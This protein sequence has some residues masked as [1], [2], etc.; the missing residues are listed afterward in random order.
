M[1]QH[2]KLNRSTAIMKNIIFILLFLSACDALDE[3]QPWSSLESFS[4]Q[5]V[6]DIPS[7]CIGKI[8]TNEDAYQPPATTSTFF[9]FL[10]LLFIYLRT[11]KYKI[12]VLYI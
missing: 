12:I 9:C 11:K 10:K 2:L 7:Q 4:N 5:E 6:T 3:C 1:I 8:P